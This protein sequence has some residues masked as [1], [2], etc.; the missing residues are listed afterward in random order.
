MLKRRMGVMVILVGCFIACKDDY[1]DDYYEITL[2]QEGAYA[3]PDGEVGY[4]AISP[5]TVT[6]KNRGISGS[7]CKT[8]LS[9]PHAS[10]FST[11]NTEKK[12]GY[13]LGGT[14]DRYNTRYT[15][16]V[17]P[18]TGL[19]AGTYSATV[20]VYQ[21]TYNGDSASFDVSFTVKPI[22]SNTVTACGEL[23]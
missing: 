4:S 11:D 13:Y 15:F 1:M 14:Y 20:T 9:G 6:V 22:F 21:D 5:L 19:S 3:F 10:C 8:R 17:Y 2:S 23:K 12:Y 7:M 16:T 18:R